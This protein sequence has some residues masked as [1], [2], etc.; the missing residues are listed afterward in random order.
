M[1]N[2]PFKV[3]RILIVLIAFQFSISD[4]EEPQSGSPVLDFVYIHGSNLNHGGSAAVFRRN[5]NRVHPILREEIP[6]NPKMRQYF[7]NGSTINPNPIP[8]YWGD[9]SKTEISFLQGQLNTP[10]FMKYKLSRVVRDKLALVLHDAVWLQKQENKQPV[11]QSLFETSQQS[12]KKDHDIFYLG[13]S[14]GTMILFDFMLYRLPYLNL[15]EFAHEFQYSTAAI[16]YI[17]TYPNQK[18]C[19]AALL[20]IN[21]VR[22]DHNGKLVSFLKDFDLNNPERYESI[23]SDYAQLKLSE[24]QE[25][26][27]RNCLPDDSIRGLITFGTPLVVFNSDLSNRNKNE[28]Y[29]TAKMVEYMFEHHMIWLNVNH[30]ND[31]LGI[32]VPFGEQLSVASK[33]LN[34][35]INR[36]GGFTWDYLT[37]SK[38]GRVYNAHSWYWHNPLPFSSAI[39]QAYANGYEYWYPDTKNP[40]QPDLTP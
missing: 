13:H 31:P 26:T 9:Q 4:A 27:E 12:L 6:A 5:V 10:L 39:I 11:L 18:S 34:L 1:R 23:R 24:L 37:L 28:S 40:N 19:L 3:L 15:S 20:N 7:L 14:C 38:G 30:I 2:R 25:A 35:I 33:K 21:A 36:Q 29:L 16:Q 22:W 17:Q 32:P 8:F